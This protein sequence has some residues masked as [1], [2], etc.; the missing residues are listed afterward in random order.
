[1]DTQHVLT[2]PHGLK[3]VYDFSIYMFACMSAVYCSD[4]HVCTC[5]MVFKAILIINTTDSYGLCDDG[6]QRD[7]KTVG[8]F[9]GIRDITVGT[10]PRLYLN[11]FLDPLMQ[12][13]R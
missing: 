9:N 3:R 5:T 7:N 2:P 8:A 11:S 13:W 12:T 6:V 4:L 10:Y 1:M